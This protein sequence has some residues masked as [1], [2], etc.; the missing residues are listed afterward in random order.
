MTE[1]V[2]ILDVAKIGEILNLSGVEGLNALGLRGTKV[3]FSSDTQAEFLRSG[4]STDNL[5][6][7]NDWL[8]Q[9]NAAGRVLVVDRVNH[10]DIVDYDLDGNPRTEAD[11]HDPAGRGMT[12]AGLNPA[13]RKKP[14]GSTT[15]YGNE[16]R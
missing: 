7:F 1:K 2:I 14:A 13:T 15:N 10:I 6:D 8:E 11:I 16:L 5:T 3:F 4:I 12:S 9:Q